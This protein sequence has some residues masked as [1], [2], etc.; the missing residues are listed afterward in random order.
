MRLA[1]GNRVRARSFGLNLFVCLV[2]V[3]A[4]GVLPVFILETVRVIEI[5]VSVS[6]LKYYSG[7][8]LPCPAD[9]FWRI[10]VACFRQPRVRVSGTGRSR[11]CDPV[12]FSDLRR[13]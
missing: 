13:K 10:I 7:G 5:H 8:L 2:G 12:Y 4:D 3:F 9:I 6:P 1:G 11:Q